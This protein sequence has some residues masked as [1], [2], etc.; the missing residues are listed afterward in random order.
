MLQ[1][2]QIEKGD[3]EDYSKIL[4][5]SKVLIIDTALISHERPKS[6]WAITLQKKN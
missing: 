2:G 1:K 3:T 6:C 5:G 4:L